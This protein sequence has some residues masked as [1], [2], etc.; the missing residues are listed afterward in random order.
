MLDPA[1]STLTLMLNG[2]ELQRYPVIGL[3]VGQPRV[4]WFSRRDPRPWQGVVWAHGELDP[5]R[6]LDRLVIQA[7]PPRKDAPE[8][9][10]PPIPPTP[11]EMYP[12]A[13]AL[14]G[15]IR[16]RA[17]DRSA[18]AR[19]RPAG[20]PAGAAPCAGGRAKWHDEIAAVFH[21]DRDRVR[22][23]LALN[24]KD[25]ASL[26][27]SLPPSVRLVILSKGQP[28]VP[29]HPVRWPSSTPSP[30]PTSAKH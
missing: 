14:P 17:V 29:S 2:A 8:P 15:A 12:G 5:P 30:S 26:Y 3:L 13:V 27:R 22:L 28:A 18:P 16:R 10:A 6:Q 20:R 23:R 4:S 19:R 7:A 9:E 24:P 21:R 25:A 1:A 11:E